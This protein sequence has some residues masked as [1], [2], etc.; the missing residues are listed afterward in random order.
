MIITGV[1]AS[2][3]K[4]IG[5]L[6]YL[7]A[8]IPE[9]GQSHN[10]VVPQARELFATVKEF[11]W[12]WLIPPWS[13]ATLGITD[14]IDAKWVADRLTPHPWATWEQPL[15]FNSTEAHTIPRHFIRCTD[16]SLESME[17]KAQSEG[18]HC[19]RLATGHDAMITV[20]ADVT[21]LLLECASGAT[22]GKSISAGRGAL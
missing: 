14:P 15:R 8:V 4:R 22:A 1:A 21:A 6:I 9:N 16:F 12:G 10:D 2:V 7:D 11:G 3:S 5:C 20:P 13:P 19:H 17:L 18:W